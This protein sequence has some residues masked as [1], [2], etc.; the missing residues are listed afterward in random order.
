MAPQYDI[1]GRVVHPT[2]GGVD[3]AVGVMIAQRDAITEHTKCAYLHTSAAVYIE[4][5]A[6]Y[7]GV[8]TDDERIYP[9]AQ[10]NAAGTHKTRLVMNNKTVV[11]TTYIHHGVGQQTVLSD[12][13]LIVVASYHQNEP[14]SDFR[15][16]GYAVVLAFCSDRKEAVTHRA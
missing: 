11:V 16:D 12:C 14:S 4:L 3:D 8:F 13:N 10:N 1:L 6:A 5:N 15:S 2:T 7:A 9:P